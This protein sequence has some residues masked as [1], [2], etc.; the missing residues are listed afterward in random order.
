MSLVLHF[1]RHLPPC[2]SLSGILYGDD[3]IAL[4]EISESVGWR[5]ERLANEL[6]VTADIYSS[7]VPRARKT[8]AH[9]LQRQNRGDLAVRLIDAFA[10]Q[11][12]GDFVGH[13]HADLAEK[14]DFQTFK[15]D[16]VFCCPP[17]GESFKNCFDRVSQ[18]LAELQSETGEKIITTHGGVLR[19]VAAHVLQLDLLVVLKSFEVSP[20][21]HLVV[22]YD[23]NRWHFS[24][25]TQGVTK[26]PLTHPALL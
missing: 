18:G 12:F 1:V 20:L 22:A 13:R 9:I 16:P 19:A 14:A 8:A 3:D 25:L 4:D 6:P 11:R 5:L 17:N 26:G 15:A 23:K 2:S 10:E 21:A 24:G 7:P